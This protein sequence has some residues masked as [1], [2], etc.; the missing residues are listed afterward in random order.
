MNEGR[1]FSILV[2]DDEK[3]NILALM[4][5]L[6][7]E[8]TV[9]AAIS[10]QNAIEMAEKHNP[11]IIL[12]DIIMPEMDSYEVITVLK[13]SKKTRNIP[14]IF[15]TGL[16]S[17]DDEEKGLALGVA[18]Y[19]IKPFSPSIVKLRIQN[20]IKLIEQ[21]RTNE[22]DIMKYK[23]A[24]DALGIALWDMDAADK[25][26]ANPDNKFTWSQEFRAMLGFS[27]ENDFPN[28]LDSW[29]ER[30]HP[31]DKEK[32]LYAFA[33]HMND[34]TGKTPYD[35]EC[36]LMMKNG[37]YRYFHALG[38]TR[39]NST[40]A[41]LRVA[42]T[43]MDITEKKRM[44]ESIRY[45]DSLLQ[46]VNHATANLL[47]S[48]LETFEDS[49][50]QS[51]KM[52][53]EAVAV[54][55]VHIWKNHETDGEL[56]CTKLYEWSKTADL[57]QDKEIKIN[58][59]YDKKLTGWK[60]LLSSGKC[61]NVLVQNMPKES[62]GYLS[63]KGIISILS[64]PVFVEDKFWGHVGFDDCHSER[65]FTEEEESILFSCSRL[66]TEAM[67]RNEMIVNIRDTSIQLKAAMEKVLEDEERIQLMLDAM[68]LACF[69]IN[70]DHNINYI[71]KEAIKLF[72]ISDE[73]DYREQYLDLL[74]EFQPCGRRSLELNN[75]YIEKTFEEGY[76]RFEW[77]YE[78]VDGELIPCD[79]TIIRVRHRGEY[80]IA[81][82]A[83]DLREQKAIIE[84]IRKVEIAEESNKAKSQFLANMS[85]EM[86]TP[87]NVVVGLV[88]LMLEENNLTVNMKENLLKI[89]TAGNTLLGLINDVLDISK[90]EAGKLELTPI[91]YT[92]PSLMNDII[93]LN[94][95]RIGSKPIKFLLDINED[96]PFSLYGDD[97]RVKQI[98]NNLLSN[99]FKYTQSG[100]IKLGIQCE[101]TAGNM[102]MSVYV[103][104]TG[105]GIREEDLKKIFIDYG[106][107]DARSN[108]EIEGTGL[109]LSITKRLAEM[110]DGGISAE[111]EYG[112]GSTFHVRIRQ[113]FVSNKT[114]GKEVVENLH[115]FRYTEDKRLISKKLVRPDLSFAKVLVVDD[116]QNNLDVASGFLGKYKMQVD[117]V[118]SGEEA[119]ERIKHGEQ[120]Y[121]AIFMDHMM[122]GMD[123]IDTAHAIRG[124]DTE[125]ARKIPIIA[126][127]ANA[128]QGTEEMF[129][130]NNFQGFLSKPI[131]IMQLDSVIKKWIRPNESDI[132]RQG[133]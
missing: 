10:G 68:P 26:L 89:C 54:D 35:I 11:D 21:L 96:L 113:G 67:L 24:N 100:T 95:I 128:I 27:D 25:D 127:T 112:K 80:I 118:S 94:I 60:E 7:P 126:L 104:D 70:R 103:S 9:Y 92:L 4:D 52:L 39:R 83:R 79:N 13:S 105:I 82:Y 109:G 77:L 97:L 37:E 88:D 106:Q 116:M 56:Y 32:V 78:K 62:Q 120:V 86:R 129:Y 132:D 74:P 119:I 55:R 81:A 19:M 22:Y 90:I 71:N 33:A 6:K 63:P 76:Q 45:H 91:E 98:I 34:R 72:G 75:E 121:N 42:G 17:A 66:F 31:E 16:G 101:H 18:D 51:M 102:W 114:I 5:I 14:V 133:G 64:V 3:S 58:I 117:C 108:R 12:L 85:H 36:R 8:Y 122:P 1:K 23:L 43:L 30:L 131:N 87:M 124:L 38:T 28:V 125:Y 61:V 41:P 93:T 57:Q 46:T 20:Q 99:A 40:G 84:E 123:G 2:V 29:I 48:D 47:N 44:E 65:T 53:A 49:L 130:A 111:S 115:G 69:L 73:K 107:V 59:S 15:V 110:M 50:Y